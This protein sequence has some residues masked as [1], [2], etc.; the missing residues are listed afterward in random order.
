VSEEASARPSAAP[1]PDTAASASARRKRD[2]TVMGIA[3]VVLALSTLAAKTAL[4]DTEVTVFRAVNELPHRL[5]TVVWPVMQ[6]GTFVTIPV[7]GAV[8]GSLVN[9]LILP[10]SSAPSP[11]SAHRRSRP[12]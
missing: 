3:A 5:H 4:T 6:Y 2:L 12:A 10:R 1:E 8:A 9:L 11:R 7:L